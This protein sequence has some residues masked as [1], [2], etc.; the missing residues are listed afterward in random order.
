MLLVLAAVLAGCS[1]GTGVASSPP[2][3]A[4]ATAS[5]SAP[6]VSPD[7]SPSATVTPTP[8]ASPSRPPAVSTVPVVSRLTDAQWGRMVAAGVWR[9]GCPVGRSGLRRVEVPYVG[10]D[11]RTHRGAL[12]V[13]ADVASSVERIFVQLYRDRFPIRRMTPVEAY[14]G[15]D[16]ASMTADNTS[17]FNCRQPGQAN[18]PSAKSPHANGRAIDLNPYENPWVDPRCHCYQPS[19][20]YGMHR[21]GKGVIV[22]GGPAWDAFTHEGWVWQDSTTTDYQ[23]FD[24]GY[25]SRPLG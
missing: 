24:T 8:T 14:G 25:P 2:S 11:G 7:P 1:S 9:A 13:N 15:D 19:V 12:V 23:H 17:A 10:F 16:N 3:A 22:K 20:Y 6:S 5:A 18:A 21:S 4:A